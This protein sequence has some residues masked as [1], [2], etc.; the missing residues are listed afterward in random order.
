MNILILTAYIA[1]WGLVHSLQAS[2]GIKN[3]LRQKFGPGVNRVYRFIYNVL[4]IIGFAPVLVL[5]R[6]LPDFGVYRVP[7]PW[8][9]FMVAGQVV[10]V[11]L[12]F[13]T[14]L[15]TDALSFVGF[16]QLME[17]DK[18]AVLV[19]N[20]VYRWVRHP[21]YLFGLSFIWLTSDMT[22]NMLVVYISL[23]IYLLVGA[24]FE[25]RKLS[26]EFGVPY[27]EYKTRTPMIIPGLI[28]KRN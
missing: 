20:G 18:P 28:I 5:M 23:T 15:Q 10:A 11:L 6:V 4:S 24:Y 3:Y 7:A 12:L 16:R 14:F 2:L 13:V 9:V 25:E 27:T 21:L 1:G 26:H 8:N 22:A 17:G 19:T